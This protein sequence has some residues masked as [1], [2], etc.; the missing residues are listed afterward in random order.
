[1]PAKLDADE[2]IA[3]HDAM[4]RALDELLAKKCASTGCYFMAELK[5]RWPTEREPIKYC[6]ACGEWA[7]KVLQTF[8]FPGEAEEI[9][10]P[11]AGQR[12]MKL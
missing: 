10:W 5:V 3:N 4:Q 2:I 9:V 7:V 6:R 11:A 1:M 12:R 8:G